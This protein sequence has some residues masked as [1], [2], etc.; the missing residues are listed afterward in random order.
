MS[1]SLALEIADTAQSLR[2]A[3][4]R[5]AAALGTTRAQWRVLARLAQQDGQRQID[6]A[7]AL[8]VEPITLCRMIDRLSEAGLVART[9]D[10]SDRRARRVHL[11]A[12]ARPV[13]E[14]L[15]SLADEF[16]AEAL[17][18]VSLEEQEVL[19]EALRRIRSNLS[20]AGRS[21]APARESTQ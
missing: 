1:S 17:G 21:A 5:R 13:V 2:R 14:S 7:D 19:G 6:L 8:D 20:D 12:K 9:A 16:F 15:R 4:D 3:F 11:T 10:D 18:G